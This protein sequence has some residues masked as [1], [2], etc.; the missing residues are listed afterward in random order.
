MVKKYYNI[1]LT[2][3]HELLGSSKSFLSNGVTNYK[4]E[5]ADFLEPLGL[6][7]GATFNVMTHRVAENDNCRFCL[8]DVSRQL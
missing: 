3:Q 2:V 6:H 8:R 4:A 5:L 1:V 7:Q